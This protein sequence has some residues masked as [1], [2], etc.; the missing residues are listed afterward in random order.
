MKLSKVE[1]RNHKEALALLEKPALTLEE[2]EFVFTHFH[3][4]AN[5]INSEAGAFFTSLDLAYDVAFATGYD[6]SSGREGKVRVLDM[7]AGIGVLSHALLHRYPHI[8]VVCLEVN[9]EYV[10]V[11]KK[12]VPEATWVKGSLDDMSLLS[13][14]RDMHFDLVV[15]NP[16]FGAVRSM[17][18][19]QCPRYKGAEAHFKCM[20][21][22]SS[23]ASNG[24]FIVPPNVAGFQYSGVQCYKELEDS[25]LKAFREQTGMMTTISIGLDTTCYGGFKGTSIRV[26]LTDYDE[27]NGELTEWPALD[28][29]AEEP[30]V[31][32][33]PQKT[34]MQPVA[35]A[36]QL[37]LGF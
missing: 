14:L 20:D 15:S 17:E 26:E 24:L 23:L 4:G 1:M 18:D 16:P 29:L 3:E 37:A 35:S 32:S 9:S 8:E 7:C 36:P 22:A 13:E 19:V 25:K 12:L 2:K 10:E 27:E 28:A 5:H 21:I 31:I 33:T 6:Y 11:G 30:V 34:P